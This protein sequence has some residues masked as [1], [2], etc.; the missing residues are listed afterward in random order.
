MHHRIGKPRKRVPQGIQ[1]KLLIMCRG[2]CPVCH[3]Y[4]EHLE[5]HHINQD[6]NDNRPENLIPLCPDC[7]SK[8]DSGEITPDKLWKHRIL[9]EAERETKKR[10][11]GY[12]AN[13]FK[14]IKQ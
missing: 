8:A 7:H 10:L 12:M 2:E 1:R 5:I 9:M 6:R 3:K 4:T 14:N 13:R 11:N